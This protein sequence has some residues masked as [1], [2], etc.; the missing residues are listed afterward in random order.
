MTIRSFFAVDLEAKP[1]LNKITEVQRDLDVPNSRIVFVAPENLH[2]T[3]KFLGDIEEAILPE[4]QKEAEKITF[5]P[6]TLELKGMGC[7]PNFSYINAIYVGATKGTEELRTIASELDQMTSKFNFKKAKRPFTA[8]LTIG[9]VKRI[10][11]KNLLI[12][13]I[14]GYAEE[15]FGEITVDAVRLKK[16]VRTPQ[17]PIYTKLF[18][19][20]AKK[21]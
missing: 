4:L 9:R 17:G 11:D 5:E 20:S 12:T 21:K 16:S 3:M 19:I 18:D 8:H 1:I 2:Y 6:F 7:L 14:K 15:L 13:K 10:Q